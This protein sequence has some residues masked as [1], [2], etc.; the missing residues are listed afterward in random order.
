MVLD[1]IEQ[2]FWCIKYFDI[3]ADLSDDD[4]QA[5]DK[6]TT[7]RELSHEEELS[8]EGVYLI[9]K[10]RI[11]IS[12]NPKET[13]SKETINTT[14][15]SESIEKNPTEP[16]TIEVLETGDIIGINTDEYDNINPLTSI[17]ALTEVC[18]GFVSIRDFMFFLKRKPHL[19][20]P[21]KHKIYRRL[22]ILLSRLLPLF[23]GYK[24]TKR[25]K[26][27]KHGDNILIQNSVPDIRRYNALSNLTFR[28]EAS[29][30]A[31][32]FQN[33]A[34]T[35]DLNG[36]VRVPRIS[37]KRIS[38]LIG[39]SM[40]S[41]EKSLNTFK[42]HNIIMMR[43]GMIQIQDL[44]KLKKIADSRSK[45]LTPTSKDVMT[46]SETL[47]FQS[48]INPQENNSTQSNSVVSSK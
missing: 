28:S 15:H 36:I 24:S 44:W 16:T 17:V 7:Y 2:H 26:S 21:P 22:L 43:W 47:D 37:K 12:D 14:T 27:T 5:L 3:F 40:E 19:V 4:T 29:R 31:F 46:T 1:L 20:L 45:T 13:D 11:K 48:L 41:T 23:S 8:E 39:C 33:L 30:L 18:V 10:G 32:L 9:K 34:T 38:R 35:P 42:Q 25:Y 6:I